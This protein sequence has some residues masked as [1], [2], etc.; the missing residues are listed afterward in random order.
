M[1]GRF[2]SQLMSTTLTAGSS[3]TELILRKDMSHRWIWLLV[4]SDQHVINRSD[5]AFDTKA[6]CAAHAR[7]SGF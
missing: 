2:A 3:E 7:A 5:S 6:A 1:R 4:T